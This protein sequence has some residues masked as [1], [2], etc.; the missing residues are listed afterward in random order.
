MHNAITGVDTLSRF[1]TT[2][3]LS[4]F[5]ANVCYEKNVHKHALYAGGQYW[6]AVMH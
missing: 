4:V 3:L 2:E 5:P 6:L 1:S